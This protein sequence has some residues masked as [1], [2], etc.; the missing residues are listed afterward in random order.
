VSSMAGFAF[1][2]VAGAILLHL[3]RPSEAIPLMMACSIS[4]QA[5]NLVIMRNQMRWKQSLFLIAGG[6]LAL[7]FALALLQ[8]G[9][10]HILRIAFGVLITLYAAYSLFRPASRPSEATAHKGRDVLIGFGGGLVGGLTAMPG[11][12]PTI[13]CDLQ[14]VPK[15]QQRGLVQPFIA[16]MQLSALVLLLWRNEL[17]STV[18][19]EFLVSLLPLWAGMMLGIRLFRRIDE[20]NFRRV[21]LVMLLLSGPSLLM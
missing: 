17:S 9:N 20:V 5:S 10:T 13:W 16:A 8:G 15:D 2:A 6:V 1:S 14:G 21:I 11:A 4:V 3:L 12:V 19:F 7:P 18:F